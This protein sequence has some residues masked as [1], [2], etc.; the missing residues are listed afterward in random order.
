MNIT[1]YVLFTELSVMDQNEELA[2][3]SG[4]AK[5]PG[6]VYVM[7]NEDQYKIG[8][9]RDPDKRL[10]QIQHEPG[11]RNTKLLKSYPANEMNRAETAAQEAVK[12]IGMVKVTQ[13]ATDW[14][15]NPGGVTDNQ[16]MEAVRKAVEEHNEQNKTHN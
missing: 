15:N 6:Y 4:C 5:G 7:K 1:Y 14:F 12:K 10:E 9:S 8:Y 2:F 16:V 3:G 11:R 13:N